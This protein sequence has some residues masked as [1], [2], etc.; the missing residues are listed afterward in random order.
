MSGGSGSVPGVP[1]SP[2][3]FSSFVGAGVTPPMYPGSHHAAHAAHTPPGTHYNQHHRLH[4]QLSVL[5]QVLFILL[6]LITLNLAFER[7]ANQLCNITLWLLVEITGEQARERM[8]VSAGMLKSELGGGAVGVPPRGVPRGAASARRVQPGPRRRPR[9]GPRRPAAA[10]RAGA[11]A[12]GPAAARAAALGHSMPPLGCP[13]WHGNPLLPGIFDRRLLRVSGRAARPKKQ[14][15]CKYC[16]RHFTKSY[17]LL[18]HERTHTDERPFPCDVCGKAFRRQDHLRDHKYIHSKEKPFK[19]GECGKGFC[20]SRT[21][22]VHKILHM[23]ESPH[24]CPTCGRSFNQR[25]NLKTHLLTHT[26]LKP[27]KCATCSAVFRRNCDL[28]RHM[29]THSIG[30]HLPADKEADEAKGAAHDDLAASGSDM[31]GADLHPAHAPLAH[32]SLAHAALAAPPAHAT[33]AHTAHVATHD[34][35]AHG[36]HAAH[37]SNSSRDSG[38]SGPHGAPPPRPSSRPHAHVTSLYSHGHGFYPVV[39]GGGAG[40]PASHFRAAPHDLKR[41]IEQVLGGAGPSG[42]PPAVMGRDGQRRAVSVKSAHGAA[43]TTPSPPSLTPS[44]PPSPSP[45]S[46]SLQFFQKLCLL[47]PPFPSPL[48]PTPRASPVL[49]TRE[50]NLGNDAPRTTKIQDPRRHA[51]D[52]ARL[53]TRRPWSFKIINK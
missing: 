35:G 30:G 17:N 45:P 43:R 29:L 39:G 32:A 48:P 21:L 44:S 50:A 27:Y 28:R 49:Q 37:G 14:F 7:F 51:P 2:S 34:P 46:S 1:P 12:G 25:S 16:S 33:H 40:P 3:V 52:H 47:P 13:A 18:I 11:P 22:A 20:Q 31:H 53:A 42:A 10:G 19:C 8:G 23:E 6:T 4:P 9:R 15:I 38:M 36:P 5:H 24:K 26:D 41:P